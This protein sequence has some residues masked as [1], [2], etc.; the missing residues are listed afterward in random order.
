MN[1]NFVSYQG[2]AGETKIRLGRGHRLGASVG[3]LS[4]TGLLFSVWAGAY[5][6]RKD[7][8]PFLGTP[9]SVAHYNIRQKCAACHQPDRVGVPD[10]ACASKDCHQQVIHNNF[11][12]TLPKACTECHPEHNNARELPAAMSNRAC[13]ECHRNLEK[14]PNSKFFTE[15]RRPHALVIDH[16][17]FLHRQHRGYH[18]PVCHGR[19]EGTIDTPFKELFT[20]KACCKCHEE[21]GCQVCHHFHGPRVF[22]SKPD[23]PHNLEKIKELKSEGVQLDL[24]PAPGPTGGAR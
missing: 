9:L 14:D 23:R 2:P 22:L 15:E 18:C 3:F 19:G 21:S 13:A 7:Q 17:R 24:P 1:P 11:H 5:F 16:R 20:M 6:Y 10:S 8:Q 4:L 12:Q